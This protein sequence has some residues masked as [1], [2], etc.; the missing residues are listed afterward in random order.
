MLIISRQWII[1]LCNAQL[2]GTKGK[3]DSYMTSN[4]TDLMIQVLGRDI[5]PHNLNQCISAI[6]SKSFG[7]KQ[8]LLYFPA[9]GCVFF[10][11]FVAT[12]LQLLLEKCR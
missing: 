1:R 2:H 3:L 7:I 6:N 11:N 12:S 9:V 4:T 8:A 5:K 10:F